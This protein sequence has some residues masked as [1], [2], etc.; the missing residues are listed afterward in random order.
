MVTGVVTFFSNSF[1]VSSSLLESVFNSFIFFIDFSFISDIFVGDDALSTDGIKI[2][3]AGC[4]T[5]HLQSVLRVFGLNPRD[6]H[7]P[8]LFFALSLVQSRGP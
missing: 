8:L 3:A 5:P 7:D 6:K 4:G 2:G 1:V